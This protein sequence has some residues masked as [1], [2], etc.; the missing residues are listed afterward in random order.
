MLLLVDILGGPAL[1]SES[2][3]EDPVPKKEVLRPR[4]SPR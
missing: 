4:F 2:N 3:H 1:A